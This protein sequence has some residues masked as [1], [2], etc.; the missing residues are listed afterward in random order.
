MINPNYHDS[1]ISV[2]GEACEICGRKINLEVHHIDY[3]EHQAIEDKMRDAKP[4][5][6]AALIAQ[7]KTLGYDE[8]NPKTKQLTKND[9]TLNT[10]VLCRNDHNYVHLLDCGKLLLN[11]LPPRR[12][13]N[14]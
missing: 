14:D 8:W 1:A 2:Y 5:E 12:E 3:Q 11:A 6:L 7:A 13:N 10:S 4:E 9:S